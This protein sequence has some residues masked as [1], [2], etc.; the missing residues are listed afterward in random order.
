M[1]QRQLRAKNG[2]GAGDVEA[3]PVVRMEMPAVQGQSTPRVRVDTS[4]QRHIAGAR[5]ENRLPG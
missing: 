2:E 3:E 4:R 1:R 5:S